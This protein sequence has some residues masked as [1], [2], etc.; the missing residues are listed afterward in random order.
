MF[1]SSVFYGE[2]LIY[3]IYTEYF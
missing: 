2:K 1:Y 3:N